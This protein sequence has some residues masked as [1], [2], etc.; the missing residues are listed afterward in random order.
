[1]IN[2]SERYVDKIIDCCKKCKH[3]KEK[4]YVFHWLSGQID[5]G[6]GISPADALNRLGYGGGA[7][8]ALDYFEVKE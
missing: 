2:S 8:A 5:E 6:S 3:S 4:I 7:V 1:M